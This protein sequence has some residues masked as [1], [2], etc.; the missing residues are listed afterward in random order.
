MNSSTLLTA[1]ISYL[2]V[3]DPIG[4]SIIF[5]GLTTRKDEAYVR[6]MAFR[7]VILSIILV[8]C[9][10]FF[11]AWLLNRLGIA[12]DSFRIAGGLLLFYTAFN[13]ITKPD[14]GNGGSHGEALEDISVYPLAIPLIAGPGCLTLTILL[15]TNAA[16]SVQETFALVCIVLVALAFTLFCLLYAKR[17]SLLIGPTANNLLNRLLGVLLASLS[18]QFIVDGIKGFIR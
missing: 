7:S 11:G 4:V 15:F 18:I 8:L 14:K 13:M 5:A 16:K 6:R 17:L 2:I 9:F 1:L 3:I 12:M 10:G